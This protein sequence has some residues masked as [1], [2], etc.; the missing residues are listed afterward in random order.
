MG[1]TGKTQQ[2]QAPDNG[3][4]TVHAKDNR[5]A[6]AGPVTRSQLQRRRNGFKPR[7][8]IIVPTKNEAGNIA[9]LIARVEAAVPEISAELIFVDDSSDETP[10]VIADAAKG[11]GPIPVSLIHR[12]GRQQA[13]GLGGAVQRGLAAAKGQWVCV[14]D[15]DLQHPPS[16]IPEMLDLARSDDAD[17]VIASRYAQSARVLGLEKGRCGISKLCI[18]AARLL[19]PAR[20]RSI[21]D[22][23]SGY[24]LLRREA[25][26]AAALRPRGFKILLEI[27]LRFP[28]LK[29]REVP[30]VFQRR[31][32]GRSKAAL[33]EAVRYGA[34]L[35]DLRFGGI[36]QRVTRF[37]LVGASGLVVNLLILAA[38]TDLVGLHYLLSAAIATL[39][40][41]LWNFS[42]TEVWVFRG[43]PAMHSLQRRLSQF[44]LVNVGALVVRGPFLVLLTSNFAVHYLLSNLITLL[45]LYGV[46]FALADLWIWG[47]RGRQSLERPLAT[48]RGIATSWHWSRRSPEGKRFAYRIH[49]ILRIDS[50]VLLPE[51]AYFR[52]DDPGERP[53]VRIRIA[54]SQALPEVETENPAGSDFSYR[55]ILGPLGFW[56]RIT[57]GARADVLASPLLRLSPHVLYTNVVEP[58]FR[59]MLVEKGYALVHAACLAV[60]GKAILL[61]APTDTG[62]TTTILQLLK[63]HPFTFLSDDMTI[64]HRD[65]LLLSYPKP[66]T[67]S[68]HTLEAVNGATIS[69]AGR[70]ALHVQSRVHS[71]SGR[72]TALSLAR[73]PLPMAS[74]NTVAQILVPPPKYFVDRL[75]PETTI[76]KEALVSHLVAIERGPDLE[77]PLEPATARSILLRNCEDAYGFP[78]YAALE[79]FLR[80]PNGTD[81]L[82]VEHQIIGEALATCPATLIR[83]Q[84][85][86]WWQR[87]PAI[88]DLIQSEE[89]GR[90]EMPYRIPGPDIAPAL[91]PD[92]SEEIQPT[93][94]PTTSL[95]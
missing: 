62:K 12:E 48:R 85:R 29:V 51:L 72:K 61:T 56:V 86:D 11:G 18:M 95:S 76:G 88:F 53:D 2:T 21:T 91:P 23:L 50:E 14:M 70:L 55:E 36:S 63:R 28:H 4:R 10:S 52:V 89:D 27:L 6:A 22:P 44:L 41:T 7:L 16:V 93:A 66:L 45:A 54:G 60:G 49:D 42:L 13:N 92:L 5:P 33:R 57:Y 43:R 32:S 81:L 90:A 39:G 25:V 59:W 78:P 38:F 75:V 8:S 17:V 71:K 46:R 69:R 84:T 20:L 37:G 65:G 31:H 34:L 77:L 74:V 24:F 19:F 67:I 35:M 58:L 9:E 3:K 1:T 80:F 26:D 83:S 87:L 68:R 30:F 40:S 79:R 94:G 73:L 47:G 64:L 15:A 82:S